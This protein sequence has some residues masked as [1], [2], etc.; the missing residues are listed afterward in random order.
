MSSGDYTCELC[1]YVAEDKI[2]YDYHYNACSRITIRYLCCYYNCRKI[3][4]DKHRFREHVIAHTEN[5]LFH[6]F[7][8]FEIDDGKKY[9]LIS[10][11]LI[12][13][14]IYFWYFQHVIITISKVFMKI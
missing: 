3:G 9:L 6:M 13:L 11:I 1:Q 12:Y 10:Y 14:F 4:H 2:D 8:L 7:L 5:T